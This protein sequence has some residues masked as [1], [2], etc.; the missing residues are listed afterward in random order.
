MC[1]LKAVG[2]VR[3][4]FGAVTALSLLVGFFGFAGT[5]S[6]YQASLKSSG[7]EDLRDA[8]QNGSLILENAEAEEPLAPQEI[9]ATAQADYKRLLAILYDNGYFGPVIRISVDGRE[10]ASL[11]AVTPP[12][13]VSKISINIKP[14]KRFRF[15][16]AN[17]R[18]LAKET[19]TV[20]SF[21]SGETASLG[22]MQAATSTAISGW[23]DEGH[24]KAALARQSITANHRD[25][26]LNAEIIIDPGRRFRFGPLT[27]AGNQAVRTERVK[28]I[29]GLPEGTVFSPKELEDSAARLRRTGTFSSVAM[30][31]AETV[32]EGT[33]LPVTARVVES[34]P[35]R[36]GIGG[37]LATLDGVTLSTFWLHRNLLGGAERLR[38]EAEIAGIGGDT[39]GIDYL[40]SARF[41]RP[42]TF[43]PDTTFFARAEIEQLDQESFFSRQ[44][45]IGAGIQRFASDQRTYT[46]GLGLRRA[47][48]RDALG[49]DDYTLFLTPASATFDYRDVA[50]DARKGYYANVGLTPFVAI[51]GSDNGLLSEVDYRKYFTF[52]EA[53]PTTIAL[54]AQLGSVFGPSLDDAPTDF[55]FYSGGGGTVR[56]HSFQSLGVDVGADDEI[57]GRSFLGFSA[58]VRAR[59]SGAL[60]FVGFVDAGYIGSEAFPDG[61]G[62]WHSGAGVG[63]RYATGI[64]PIRV[65]LAVPTSGDDEGSN[66][67]IY[68]GI[69]HSF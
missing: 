48:T 7:D 17:V 50:L 29:A 54:R 12:Q 59:T 1:G 20:E 14:G 10:A 33:D 42:A 45:S 41:E 61:S 31:E 60:G 63:V 26:K 38:L 21:K 9:I 5:A 36:F 47:T 22:A 3:L 44:F 6:A 62:E 13:R 18:P 27:V 65:D 34:K 55:L 64:G 8:L 35:R 2:V 58:E 28:E 11:E 19:D 57:G 46:F 56:G 43:N 49:S 16:Q 52:G 25:R 39:G 66:F 68:I 37:E 53:R 4:A 30:I 69:G 23:R 67:Q 24:A 40:L 51:S 32:P 15:G